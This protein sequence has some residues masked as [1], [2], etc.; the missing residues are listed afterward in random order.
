MSLVVFV[1]IGPMG[2]YLVLPMMETLILILILIFGLG[3]SLSFYL[4]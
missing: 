3:H 4:E 2:R 1:L